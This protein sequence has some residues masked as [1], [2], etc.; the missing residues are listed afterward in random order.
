M[1]NKARLFEGNDDIAE[2]ILAT[3]QPSEIK[4]LGRK[5]RNFNGA[6]WEQERSDIVFQGNLS[7]FNQNPALAEILLGTGDAVLVEASPDDRIWGVGLAITDPNIHDPSKWEGLNLLGQALMDVR[8]RLK[9]PS[10][11]A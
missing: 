9:A 8:S 3:R 4:K 2:A 1:Y 7:K 5:V 10:G 6:V 11:T